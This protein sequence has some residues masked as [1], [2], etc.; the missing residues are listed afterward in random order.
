MVFALSCCFPLHKQA[1]NFQTKTAKTKAKKLQTQKM[2][3]KQCA[4]NCKKLLTTTA[5][6]VVCCW[7]CSAF[8]FIPMDSCSAT[9]L[10]HVVWCLL[11]LS[12]CFP[13]LSNFHFLFT[14]TS[15]STNT[16]TS[17]S[18]LFGVCS[19][20]LAAFPFP[21]PIS[22]FFSHLLCFAFF[23]C[24]FHFHRLANCAWPLPNTA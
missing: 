5:A 17:T 19:F 13:P 18:M 16:N 21:F 3:K 24:Q 2:Q 12:C 23:A 6:M 20:F 8:P 1:Q 4:N 11:F 15:T 10:S 22:T 7:S 9:T 14:S